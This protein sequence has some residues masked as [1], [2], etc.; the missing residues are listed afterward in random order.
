ML[1]VECADHNTDEE[2]NEKEATHDDKDD[3]EDYPYD[4]GLAIWNRQIINLGGGGAEHHQFRPASSR[5]SHE[6]H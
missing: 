3:E 2:I 1:D 6:K 4:A 5:G